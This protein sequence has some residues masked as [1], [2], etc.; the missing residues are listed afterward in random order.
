MSQRLAIHG[1]RTIALM[2]RR[3]QLA[4]VSVLRATFSSDKGPTDGEP[5]MSGY[6]RHDTPNN[7][8]PSRKTGNEVVRQGS[9]A[10]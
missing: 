10:A 6:I 8:P 9:A 5:G 3:A 4:P 7:K 1:G 2:G